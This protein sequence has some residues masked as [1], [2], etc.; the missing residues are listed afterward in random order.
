M[1][2]LTS[3]DGVRAQTRLA[4][5]TQRTAAA[6]VER[7]R[8][9]LVPAR[10]T[11]TP[12]APFA[13]LVLA[14]LALGVVGLLLFNTHM[15]QASFQ[16]T[17]LQQ[18]ADDLVAQ[19]QKLDMELQEL[20]DPQRLAEA[21]RDLGLVA[22]PVP[23]FIRLVDG[24]VLGVPTVATPDDYVPVMGLPATL[25]AELDPEPI[26]RTVRAPKAD[27]R[28]NPTGNGP[29]SGNGAA[30][31]GTNESPANASNP[32]ANSSADPQGAQR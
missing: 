18:Q 4:G 10:R 14:V 8:L 1:S 5:R 13:V 26:I 6:A 20:R 22:P 16:A 2:S 30:G 21:G 3:P 15:Q 7:A 31:A 24:K 11:V 25:P 17:A 12:R 27:P 28:T 29:A 32:P 19:Q 9:S 23:A